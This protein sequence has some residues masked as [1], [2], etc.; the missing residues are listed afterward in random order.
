MDSTGSDVVIAHAG[1]DTATW[2]ARVV[3]GGV[4]ESFHRGHVAVV[5]DDGK[6]V[7]A[8]GNPRTLTYVRSAIKPLQAAAVLRLVHRTGKELSA[9]SLAIACASHRG[10]V[11]QQG[12]VNRVLQ[13][14]G[15]D[16]RSL[17]CPPSLP[18]DPAALVTQ[19][20]KASRL[21]HNCSGKHAAFL[22]AEC[23]AGGDLESY[24]NHESVV[25]R[26]VRSEVAQATGEAPVG[27]AVDGCGAPAW[28]CT[29]AGLATAFSRLASDDDVYGQIRSAM[30]THPGLI[31]G[32]DAADT[33]LMGSNR[34]IV[35]KH[36]AEA[37]FAAG[38][39]SPDGPLGIAVKILDGGDRAAGAVAAMVLHSLGATIPDNLLSPINLA[40]DSGGATLEVADVV[41]SIA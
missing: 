14:A 5:G 17:Q 13:A 40:G 10:S 34:Q 12:E 22:L 24:L 16:E 11:V 23:V 30:S 41:Q 29:V 33:V 8:L 19:A 25:Q 26:A 3:R 35:A 31:G 28:R 1:Q 7:T 32:P 38:W 9:T 39:N 20:G 2:V 21:A 37:V 18:A 6:V 4:F 15:L 27:P 36:G